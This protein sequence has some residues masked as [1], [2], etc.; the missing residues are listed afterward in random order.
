MPGRVLRLGHHSLRR[1]WAA[2]AA[3]TWA[4]PGLKNRRQVRKSGLQIH[5][6]LGEAAPE[7]WAGQ[8]DQVVVR[9]GA[10]AEVALFHRPSAT[11]VLTDLVVNL[12]PE[13]IPA[14]MRP[15]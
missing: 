14:P 15:P 3:K 8:I 10:F 4:A 5:A 1:L 2:P 7:A 6:E 9:A 13:R 11:L 12:E